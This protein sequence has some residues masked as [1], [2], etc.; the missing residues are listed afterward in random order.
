MSKALVYVGL[1]ALALGLV[2]RQAGAAPL[3]QD[4][5]IDGIVSVEAEHF[6]ENVMQ[7]NAQW[8]QV[9]PTGGFTGVAGM[10]VTGLAQI[11]EGYAA[12]S[13]RLD[14]Q[15][16]FVKTGT[17]YVW[18]RGWGNGGGDDS[19]HTGLDG[20]EID[21]CDRMQ[22]WNLNYTW[23]NSSM[24]GP[25]STFEVTSVGIHT[26][27]L[28][29]R[30][31]G[32]I[33]DKIVLTTNPD[34][35]PTGDGPAENPRGIPA[36]ATVPSPSDGAVDVPREVTLAWNP[37]PSIVAHDVYFGTVFDDVNSATRANPLGVLVSQSQTATTYELAGPLALETTYY[38]RVDEIGA[39]PESAIIKGGVWRFTTEPFVYPIRN[40]TVAASG[41]QADY[42]P[43][44]TINGSGLD[45]DDLH[46]A[47]QEDM[48]LVDSQQAGPVWIQYEFDRVYKL[49]ELWVWNYNVIFEAVIGYGFKDVTIE[50]S[51]DGAEWTVLGDVQFAKAPASAGY[52]HNTT[53][54][55]AGIAA[56]YV[57][58]TP[59]SNWG[60][61]VAQ[62][63][64]SEVRF[65]YVP[66]HPRQPQ[67][68]NGLTDVNPDVVLA[69]RTG[70]EAASHEVY[71]GSDLDAV[72]G[73]T[74][75][76][77]TVEVARCD[78]GALD[79]GTTYYWKVVEV[80]EAASPSAWEGDLW[81][82]STKPHATVD[83]FESYTDDV[84][85]GTTIFDTWL[86]GWVNETGSTVGYL[87]APFAEKTIVH[88]GKQSMPLAYDNAGSPWYSETQR[89]FDAPQ[90]WTVHGANTLI[91]HFQGRPS[92]FA[93][94]A[95]GQIIMGAAGVDIWEAAD[96]FRFAYKRLNGNGSIVARVERVVD[97]DPW[98]KTGVMIRASLAPGAPFAAVY[99]TG[100]NGVRY[101]GRLAINEAA[102]SDTSVATPEQIALREPAW[103]KLERS[104]STFNGYYSTDGQNWTAM[105]WNP[106]TITMAADVYVGLAA[107]S[108]SAGVLTTVEFSGVQTTGNVS[109]G[110]TVETIGPA[111]PEGNS[112]DRL[113]VAVKDAAGKKKTV[114]HPSGEVAT[115]LAGWN[116]WQISFDDL[117]GIDL[118]RVSAMDIGV[119]NL[120]N[121]A[122]G[123]A[124]LIYI[125][126]IAFGRAA[127]AE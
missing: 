29:M 31:D 52:A 38:W 28:W 16:S 94:L 96:E 20:E 43:E 75:L 98:V 114:Y 7:S 100:S 84:D 70:R 36:Y 35:V 71:F 40:V 10:Q 108:H 44:N 77:D 65:Y 78:P 113:Y 76:I 111:Q 26:F 8:K 15:I 104:G 39:A 24:D 109:G 112:S 73:G 63:G 62:Y 89:V 4:G 61:L 12:T 19:C 27:N 60:G 58:L 13:P 110:W 85:A 2:C 115:L 1:V 124:G 116:Q 83:D 80:N 102:T 126:D 67:P 81:S 47:D 99:M 48:W 118:G 121:P 106:Q 6:D 21:T 56:K 32:L 120:D 25:R 30:E 105:S 22:G 49:Q 90:D 68:A 119:G 91:V 11:N 74:A 66:A 93:E 9:G 3:Q 34:Y 5:G 117:A 72:A 18:I 23:S 125:D 82:F 64:L 14:Y 55:M 88:G 123:G 46:S 101:Q 50:Y 79:F 37:G 127:S 33:V 107:C 54:D 53:V 97:T 59:G 51:T 95:S 41:F 122:A 17:H 57:R 42:R 87:N 92:A 103:I 69:W 45:A 86:D